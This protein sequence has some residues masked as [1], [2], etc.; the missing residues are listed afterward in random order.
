MNGPM[1]KSIAIMTAV[2]GL[3]LLCTPARAQTE[4]AETML[5]EGILRYK[6]GKFAQ[7]S[8]ILKRALRKAKD[9]LVKGKIHLYLGLNLGVDGQKTRAEK[10]F[11]AALKLDPTLE[12]KK[13]ETKESI[14]AIFHKARLSLTGALSVTADRPGAAVYVDGKRVGTAPYTGPVTV[15]RHVVEVTTADAQHGYTG[16]VLVRAGQAHSVQVMLKPLTGGV[17]VASSPTGA[18]VKVDGKDRGKAPAT[19]GKLKPG[20]HTVELSLEGHAP[21]TREIV[22]EAGKELSLTIKLEKRKANLP[23]PAL[24]PVAPPVKKRGRLWTWVAAG[25][26]VAMAGV[27]LGFG[28]WAQS[29]YDEYVEVASTSP[30]DRYDELKDSVPTRATVSTIGFATAGALAITAAVLFFLEPR[31]ESRPVKAALTPGG[32]VFG[33]EF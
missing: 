7:S 9:P 8:K 21:Q 32:A 2:L 25:S 26:A 4:S 17:K 11:R 6:V 1:R 18:A 19:A 24:R 23:S 10:A 16:K 27:G 30:R 12:L 5:H 13:S 31:G 15:G 20:K 29:G 28:L 22:V 33:Y 14:L 3:L